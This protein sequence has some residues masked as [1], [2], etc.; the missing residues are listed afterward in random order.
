MT[1]TNTPA[2]PPSLSHDPSVHFESAMLISEFMVWQ[3][4]LEL[5]YYASHIEA[6]H[7]GNVPL[8]HLLS[9]LHLLVEHGIAHYAGRV[10]HFATCL[11]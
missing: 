1:A 6:S 7:C 3:G 2:L 11:I 9:S 10:L 4:L 8:D 5:C